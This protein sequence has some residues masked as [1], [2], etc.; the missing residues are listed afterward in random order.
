M[1]AASHHRRMEKPK[2]AEDAEALIRE[3][4][5]YLRYLDALRT[6]SRPHKR[7]GGRSAT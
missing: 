1:S 2:R 5:R 4:Q 6:A 7:R 3:I